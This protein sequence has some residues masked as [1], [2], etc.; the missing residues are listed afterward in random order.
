[1]PFIISPD[2]RRRAAAFH[3]RPGPTPDIS[4]LDVH[5][6]NAFDRSCFLVATPALATKHPAAY[7]HLMHDLTAETGCT[8][9]EILAHGQKA[10]RRLTFVRDELRRAGA[11]TGL[12]GRQTYIYDL[13]AVRTAF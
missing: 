12:V 2:K 3:P 7:R 9:A 8:E 4:P 13:P 5:W 1:M 11:F 10:R 6:A